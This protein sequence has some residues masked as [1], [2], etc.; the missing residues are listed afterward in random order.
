M[1]ICSCKHITTDD[2]Q[3]AA[4]YVVE[5]NPKKVLNMLNWEAECGICGKVLV[6]EIKKIFDEINN[7]SS[8]TKG[9]KND[10]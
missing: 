7:K 6:E 2:I 3:K 10:R 5:P 4:D 9:E 8:L 1:I